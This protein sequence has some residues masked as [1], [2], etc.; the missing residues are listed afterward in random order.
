VLPGGHVVA[1]P[2][3]GVALAAAV[4]AARDGKRP[5]GVAEARRAVG[6]G[7]GHLHAVDIMGL[8]VRAGLAVVAKAHIVGESTAL[9]HGRFVHIG[10]NSFHAHVF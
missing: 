7:A 1:G 9:E 10:P 5:V 6:G 3:R 4:G 8:A 2:A